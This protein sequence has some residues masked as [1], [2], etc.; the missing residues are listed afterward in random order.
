MTSP[1]RTS[2]S[3]W[4]ANRLRAASSTV[5][6][7]AAAAVLALAI[8][9]VYGPAVDTP[10]IFDDYLAIVGNKSITLLWPFRGT[11]EHVGP[12]SPLPDIPTSGRPFVNLSFAVN[13]YFGGLNPVGYHVVNLVIHFLSAMLLWAIVRRTLRLPYFAGRFEASAGW[14]ALSVALLWAIH[15][16]QTEAV[17]YT[18]QRTELMM[19]LCYLATLYCSLRYWSVLPLPLGEGRGEGDAGRTKHPHPALSEGE[20]VRRAMWLALAVFACLAGMASKEV[21][22]SAPLMVLLFERT[23]IAG[24]LGKAL[25]NSWPLYAGLGITWLLL[26]GLCLGKPH[27][28]SAGFGL[29]ISGYDWW[30]TQCKAI[31]LYWKLAVWPWPLSIHYQWPYLTSF[32][33]VW[34]YVIPVVAVGIVTLLLLWRNH[35]VG[36]LS[37][38]VFAILLPTSTV[39]ILLEV[40]AERRM[41][42]PLAAIVVLAFVSGYSLIQLVMRKR[43]AAELKRFGPS[44]PRVVAWLPV[45]ATAIAYGLVSAQR[46]TAYADEMHLWQETLRFQPNDYVAR[47]NLGLLLSNTGR[48]QEAVE[49]F[50]AV[51]AQ[52]PGD[53]DA[54]N[55]LG[56]ALTRAGRPAEAV[57]TLKSLLA[58]QPDDPIAHTNLGI[59]LG[60]SSHF[61]EAIDQFHEALRREPDYFDAHNY[62]GQ[63]LMSCGRLPE[64]I[65]ELQAA[66]AL[67]PD[68][69]SALNNLGVALLTVGRPAESI[70][71]FERAVRL[72]PKDADGH[73]NLATALSNVGRLEEAIK[74][75]RVALSLQPDNEVI[76]KNL[77]LA[78]LQLG[79]FPEAIEHLERAVRLRPDDADARDN[80]GVA[81]ASIGKNSEAIEQFRLA[82]A[83]NPNDFHAHNNWG[84]VLSRSGNTE[85]A[86][87]HFEEA[88]RLRPDDADIQNK[89]G[90]GL[91]KAGRAKEAIYH[92]QA[93]LQRKPDSVPVLANLAQALASVDR[94]DEAVA[95]AEHAIELARSSGDAAAVDQIDEWLKHYRTELRR[96]QES[97][98]PSQPSSLSP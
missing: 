1:N 62:L 26:L 48:V 13:Y 49:Q 7:W 10:F 15:P 55:N 76:L 65:Q 87:G 72:W 90:D 44:V 95:A 12:L 88:L 94:P 24:S 50:Q 71:Q 5:P 85:E 93:S 98:S 38:C 16:L 82:L 53:R 83:R 70:T 63:T 17:I 33:E 14:L 59:V 43:A 80:L 60:R 45:L 18:T 34:M 2:Q 11:T 20:R 39:P 21:M 28:T 47:Y 35:P 86:I 51:L 96:R 46:L 25:R 92:Y 57:D 66:L 56:V 97:N 54:L 84:E 41:Y 77:A 91:R 36:Y 27:A 89:L 4:R 64:A 32:G 19:A 73:T 79:R 22:V 74:E 30:L 31:L 9:V 6:A 52:K 42:L 23:F 37:T 67:K 61:P 75:L 40:A 3:Q 8:G 29:G 78:L 69:P 81:L 68:D 58:L